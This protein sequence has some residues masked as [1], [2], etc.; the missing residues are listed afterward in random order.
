MKKLMLVFVV[1]LFASIVGAAESVWKTDFNEAK[2]L[3]TEKKLPLLINF[4]GSNWCEKCDKLDK[5]VLSQKA[6]I[7]YAGKN[8]ILVNIDFP[9]PDNRSQAQK[10]ASA[11]LAKEYGITSYPTLVVLDAKNQIVG[12][13][14][15]RE[16]GAEAYVAHLKE[17]VANGAPQ[18]AEGEKI[19]EE[20]PL[21]LENYET[22]I[23]EAKERGVPI[24]VD[25]TGS[26]WCGWCIKL[27]KEVFGKKEFAE[28]AKK[29]FVLLKLDFPRGI[30]QTDEL[31]KQNAELAKKYKVQGFP[32]IILISSDGKVIAQTGYQRGGVEN[33]IKHLD[34]FIKDYKAPK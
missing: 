2:K 15:Y 11:A 7:D 17:I 21:W 8:F 9:K 24:L 19:V 13:T 4:T 18:T 27:D 29:K 28:Y 6:F 20:K 25:F 23:K 32:T 22:A 30:K 10:D 33:Y 16:G 14:G 26:D 34:E 5:E 1:M 31:K 3:S 12:K